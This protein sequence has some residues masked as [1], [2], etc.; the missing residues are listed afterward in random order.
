[1]HVLTICIT[2]IKMYRAVVITNVI[3]FF[4]NYETLTLFRS[5]P[6]VCTYVVSYMHMYFAGP[7][8]YVFLYICMLETKKIVFESL[9]QS[10]II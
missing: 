8:N 9:Y 7:T 10:K 6:Y 1:M 5:L 2:Y 4:Y 3:M